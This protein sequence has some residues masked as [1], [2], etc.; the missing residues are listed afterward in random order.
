MFSPD[1]RW[2]VFTSNQ[3][4]QDEIY[5]KPYPSEGGMIQ[6]SMNGGREPLWARDGSELFYRNGDKMMVV[7]F[8]TEP[9]LKAGAP[10]LLFEGTYVYS[11]FS[12]ASYYDISPD[13]E[14]LLMIKQEEGEPG[15][16]NVVLNW[17]EE[18]KR[19]VPTP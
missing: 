8:Q 7:S 13:G 6:I 10:T 15:Q 11:P 17:F 18:L 4:G 2:I 19:L 1:G 5:V 3:S 14:R 9:T 12:W 16:I